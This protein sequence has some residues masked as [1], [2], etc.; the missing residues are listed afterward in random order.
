MTKFLVV[1]SVAYND[2]LIL[3]ACGQSLMKDDLNY[4]EAQLA[5]HTYNK[6]QQAILMI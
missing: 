3:S 1:D 2:K 6:W 5:S 4:I